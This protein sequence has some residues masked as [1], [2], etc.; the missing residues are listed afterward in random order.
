MKT[1]YIRGGKVNNTA[2][3][4][5]KHHFEEL[6]HKVVRD[7]NDPLGW[8]VG[9][10]WG[11][12]YQGPKPF[13]NA[14]VNRFDKFNCF[15]EFRDAGVLCPLTFAVDNMRNRDY[16]L[17]LLNLPILAR[18]KH[19]TKGKDIEVCRTRADVERVLHNGKHA[20]FSVWIPTDTEY[21]VWVF[22]N[23]A[24]AVYEKQYK[25]EG[26]YEGFCRNRRFGFSFEKR[27][28]LRGIATIEGPCIK[29]VKALGMDWGAVDILKGKDRKY[30]VLE[31]NSMP[32]IDTIKR[33][34]GIRLAKAVSD[35]AE[36]Q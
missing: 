1:I 18:K 14:N 15:K 3:N 30:Y 5:M 6:G 23:K 35:W 24:L 32:H 7:K 2:I 33:S 16:N 25:D 27:D 12:S 21:R 19:H 8:D 31:V 20:F 17:L 36:A 11:C 29:A 9:L 34:S 4:V 22:K 13:L 28:D 26:E 10:S